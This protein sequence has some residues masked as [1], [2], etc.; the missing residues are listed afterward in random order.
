MDGFEIEWPR[1]RDTTPVAIVSQSC[2]E[3]NIPEPECCGEAVGIG[4]YRL[5]AMEIQA[6]TV[7]R[8]IASFLISDAASHRATFRKLILAPVTHA[9]NTNNQLLLKDRLAASFTGPRSV[10]IEATP[11]RQY[12]FPHARAGKNASFL[13]E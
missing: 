11:N 4:R 5:K 12:D 1:R 8:G 9:L 13:I 6:I 2:A 3:G 7:S 10:R